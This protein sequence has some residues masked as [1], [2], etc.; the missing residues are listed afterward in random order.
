MYIASI[1]YDIGHENESGE[2]QT[3]ETLQG[4]VD[5]LNAGAIFGHTVTAHINNKR[6]NVLNKR[7]VGKDGTPFCTNPVWHELNTDTFPDYPVVRPLK[8][9]NMKT[10]GENYLH[11]INQLTASMMGAI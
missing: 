10:R 5:W 2:D 1:T 3:F 4:A 11:A 8:A 7:L 9:L 6:V